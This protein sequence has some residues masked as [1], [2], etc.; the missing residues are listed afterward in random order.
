MQKAIFKVLGMKCGSCAKVLKY[1]LEE[2]KGVNSADIDFKSAKAHLEF[3]PEE[4]SPSEIENKIKDL[5]YK[6]VEE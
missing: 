5:G 2:A 3:D 6:A 4:I 1:G